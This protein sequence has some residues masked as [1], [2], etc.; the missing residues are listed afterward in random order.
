MN[1]RKTDKASFRV[2]KSVELID[3]I[4]TK[5]LEVDSSSHTFLIGY[6]LLPTH[7]TNKEIKKS[8]FYDVKTKQKQMMQYP[9]NNLQDC[10]YFHYNLQLSL[11]AW[12]IKKQHPELNVKSLTPYT[13][14]S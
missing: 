6:G 9:L 14:R 4:E 10:N 12:M 8:S 5:C 7:N 3:T 2:V 13:Y 1:F 11:Y